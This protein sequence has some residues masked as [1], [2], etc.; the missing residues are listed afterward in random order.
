MLPTALL[1]KEQRLSRTFQAHCSSSLAPGLKEF[2]L[3]ND[4][5][6][7][8]VRFLTDS[9]QLV[10]IGQITQKLVQQALQQ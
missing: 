2:M 8:R 4:P 7:R 6:R 9:S 3:E 1:V 5:R 10:S